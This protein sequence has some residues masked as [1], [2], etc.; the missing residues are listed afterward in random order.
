M[1]R[2]AEDIL[3]VVLFMVLC[4]KGSMKKQCLAK[5]LEEIWERYLYDDNLNYNSNKFS[6]KFVFNTWL[7]FPAK[8]KQETNF[9]QVGD[10]VSSICFFV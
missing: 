7:S 5:I 9:Q 8:Q 4:F 3:Q 1:R 6:F 2:F 10:L